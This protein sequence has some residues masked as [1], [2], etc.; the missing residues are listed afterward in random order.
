MPKRM[1]VYATKT[2][3]TRACARELQSYLPDAEL[4]DLRDGIPYVTDAYDTVILGGSIRMGTL[5]RRAK[6]F[7][8]RNKEELL[9]G[10]VHVGLFI[11]NG[12]I[13]S[14]DDLLEAN[15]PAGLLRRADVVSTFGGDCDPEKQHGLDKLILKKFLSAAQK[16]KKFEPPKILH[17]VIRR[18]AQEIEKAEAK[19]LK[20]Q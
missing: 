18:F 1:I 16:N 11:C 4:Y 3:T 8:V 14:A 9:S 5:N 17:G 15:I 13:D 6:I 10:S 2:G 12:V 19:P 20:K 7:I